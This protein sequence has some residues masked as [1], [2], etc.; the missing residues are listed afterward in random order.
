[1]VAKRKEKGKKKKKEKKTSQNKQISILND[2]LQQQKSLESQS[3][4]CVA[5]ADMLLSKTEA[6]TKI[7]L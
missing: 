7:I 1:M 4:Y 6:E 5:M 2:K 3:P